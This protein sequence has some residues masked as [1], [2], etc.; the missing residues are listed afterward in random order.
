MCWEVDLTL[1]SSGGEGAGFPVEGRVLAKIIGKM[2]TV[3]PTLELR[4]QN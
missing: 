4:K 3:F 1:L 2:V